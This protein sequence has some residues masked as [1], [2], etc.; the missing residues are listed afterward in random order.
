MLKSDEQ[1]FL[2]D[3]QCS[4]EEEADLFL[5]WWSLQSKINV[6]AKWIACIAKYIA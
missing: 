3:V 2:Q 6:I 4:Q 1:A 5:L